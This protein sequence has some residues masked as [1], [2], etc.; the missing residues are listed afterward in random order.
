MKMLTQV[1]IWF[2]IFGEI[3]NLRRAPLLGADC[4]SP[5]FLPFSVAL[6][7]GSFSRSKRE[8][9]LSRNFYRELPCVGVDERL[10]IH[11]LPF[12]PSQA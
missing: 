3:S 2:S 11:L 6:P 9:D 7:L 4:L 12:S 5:A 8:D 10:K 1:L